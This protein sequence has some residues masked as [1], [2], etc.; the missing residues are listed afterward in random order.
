MSRIALG[1]DHGGY[2]LKASI[3]DY[4]K[5]QGHQVID[6]GTHTSEPVDYPDY[7][8]AVGKAL[9]QEDADLGILVCGSGVG[10]TVA[11]NKIPGI[12]AGMCHDSFSARQARE[13]DNTNVLCLG[14][15]VIGV[16]LALD[17]VRIWLN[18]SFSGA[19]RH[20]RRLGKVKEMERMGLSARHGQ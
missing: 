17:I 11:A 20:V 8:L 10:V 4:L 15:R 6:L 12:R 13:D 16:Q 1:A 18:S 19:E 5:A 9:V 3:V 7:A 14:A 2:L